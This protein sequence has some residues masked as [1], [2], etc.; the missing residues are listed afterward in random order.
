[1]IAA[2]E[3]LA[4]IFY[5]KNQLDSAYKYLRQVVV[6]KDSLFS[7]EKVNKVQSLS[8]NES[9]RKL[10]EEQNKKEAVQEY[11]SRVKIYSLAAGL[12]GLLIFNFYP[13]QK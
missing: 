10:Q 7:S 13:L 2:A 6:S 4:E 11:K 12:A 3:L 5:E 1:M 9:L 8:L